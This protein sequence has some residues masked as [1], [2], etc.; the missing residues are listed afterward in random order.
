M[1][2][3]ATLESQIGE[4]LDQETFDPPKEFA[5]AAVVT[6]DSVY[7]TADQDYESFWA[8]QAEALHWN[9]KWDQVLDWSDPPHA[10]WFVGGKLNVAYNCVDRHV[11]AGNDAPMTEGRDVWYHEACK[12]AADECPAEA[13]DAEHPLYILYSSGSTAKPKG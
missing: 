13:L 4:L 8:E 10:K 11:E 12:A 1:T 3:G 9:Q 5:E 7:E 6:D 2:E